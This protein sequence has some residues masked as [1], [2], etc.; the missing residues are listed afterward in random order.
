MSARHPAQAEMDG[1]G[2]L[3]LPGAGREIGVSQGVSLKG[4]R[5]RTMGSADMLGR[6]ELLLAQAPRS[7]E[8]GLS[9]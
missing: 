5:G 7:P 8:R 1:S 4:L 6:P 2:D 9:A 3:L